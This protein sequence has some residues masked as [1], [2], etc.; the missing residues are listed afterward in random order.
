MECSVWC[1]PI[2]WDIDCMKSNNSTTNGPFPNGILLA[3]YLAH[4][5]IRIS[6]SYRRRRFAYPNLGTIFYIIII[7]CVKLQEHLI[8]GL[9]NTS[10][11]KIQ[12]TF[13]LKIGEP[14]WAQKSCMKLSSQARLVG[15]SRNFSSRKGC[16]VG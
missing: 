11:T 10:G 5:H 2:C 7:V 1:R 8:L 12:F 4:I 3:V 13:F 16:L 9:P 14:R 15:S 6:L